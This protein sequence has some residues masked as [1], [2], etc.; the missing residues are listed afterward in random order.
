LL[1]VVITLGIISL[2]LGLA[3]PSFQPWNERV[4]LETELATIRGFAEEAQWLALSTRTRHWL[5]GNADSVELQ[6]SGNSGSET[7]NAQPLPPDLQVSAT[8]WPSFSAFGFAQ[9]GTITLR[10]GTHEGKV[11]VS[12][13]GRI[14]I[15]GPNRLN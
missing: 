13:L 12:P 6:R 8:R 7:L 14:R 5:A 10:S 9:G 15:T 2:L 4:Q 3:W 1:E 11:V